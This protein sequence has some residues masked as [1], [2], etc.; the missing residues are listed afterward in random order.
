[1]SNGAVPS[2]SVARRSRT[3]LFCAELPQ[4]L[5][6]YRRRESEA[7]GPARTK[8]PAS[9][10]PP[11]NMCNNS[12][13]NTTIYTI[14]HPAVNPWLKSRQRSIARS[15]PG[16]PLSDG[17]FAGA[18]DMVRRASENLPQP[19]CPPTTPELW[20]ANRHYV[21][22]LWQGQCSEAS[23]SLKAALCME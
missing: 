2:R 18:C 19:E 7:Q 5:A 13:S 22:F 12:C 3:A 23:G 15:L 17:F 10:L 8:S 14:E 9:Q 6:E 11:F 4:S 21:V 20:Y 1:M 16:A